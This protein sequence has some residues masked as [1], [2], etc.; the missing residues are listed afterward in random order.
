MPIQ[1][2]LTTAFPMDEATV[3]AITQKMEKK[4]GLRLNLRVETDPELI[5]GFKVVIMFAC[6]DYSIGAQLPRL[7]KKLIADG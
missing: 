6:Y 3:R 5:A 4:T 2:V 7:R 1:G